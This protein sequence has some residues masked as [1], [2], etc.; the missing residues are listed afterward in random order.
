MLSVTPCMT[1]NMCIS[2]VMATGVAALFVRIL[3][4]SWVAHFEVMAITLVSLGMVLLIGLGL[5]MIQITGGV[6]FRRELTTEERR[7]VREA[8]GDLAEGLRAGVGFSRHY[9]V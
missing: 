9:E 8:I 7:N 4:V 1:W 3:P 2:I 6:K 5:T